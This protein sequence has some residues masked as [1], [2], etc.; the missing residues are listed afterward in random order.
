MIFYTYVLISEHDKKFYVGFTKDLERRMDEHNAGLVT[1][2]KQRRPLKLAYYEACMNQ[3][4]ALKREKYFKSGYGRRFLNN[5]IENFLK[6]I[7]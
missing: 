3:N 5:R 4:D 1:S 7:T 2:T 6:E